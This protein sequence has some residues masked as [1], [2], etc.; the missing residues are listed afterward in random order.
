MDGRPLK[1]EVYF[2]FRLYIVKYFEGCFFAAKRAC[3]QGCTGERSICSDPLEVTALD[4]FA[5]GG[6]DRAQPPPPG[7]LDDD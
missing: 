2:S 7:T 5:T 6:L 1:I 4:F 3:L